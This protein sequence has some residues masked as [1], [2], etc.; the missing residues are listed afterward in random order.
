MMVFP[1]STSDFSAN[2]HSTNCFTF[3]NHPVIETI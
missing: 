2:S 1:P 3:I